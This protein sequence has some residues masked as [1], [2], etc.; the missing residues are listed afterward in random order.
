MMLDEDKCTDDIDDIKEK[1]RFATSQTELWGSELRI[2]VC[3]CGYRGTALV[4]RDY[5][6]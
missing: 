5:E 3:T 6:R 1:R 2:V 4:E